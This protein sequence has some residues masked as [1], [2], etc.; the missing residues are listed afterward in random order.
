MTAPPSN[1][2]RPDLTVAYTTFNS[3]R[4]IERSVR[5]V[6]PVCRRVVVVDSGST[7]GT[8]EICRELGCEVV[9]KPWHGYVKSGS[10][11]LQMQAAIDLADDTEWVMLL[12]S[13]ECLTQELAES[14]RIAVLANDP[15]V[16]AYL[17]NRRHWYKGGW[18]SADF[19]DWKLRLFRRGRA[20]IRSRLVHEVP[21]TDG[22]T[23]RLEG[24]LR[25]ES[26]IDL[27]DALTRNIR[28]ARVAGWMPGRRTSLLKIVCNGP[29]AFTRTFLL[30][31][32]FREGW[33]GLEISCVFGV[34]TL[35]KHLFIREA[36]RARAGVPGEPPCETHE[37]AGSSS[38]AAKVDSSTR[39]DEPVDSAT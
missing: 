3:I 2:D 10:I 19:P 16:D 14:I 9:H 20:W 4:T 26:W 29:W 33:R 37:S 28:Y 25:H 39:V 24:L 7:D 35:M 17:L 30:Q 8:V 22:P 15:N 38:P 21:E 32:G 34:S 18:I 31:G 36:M 5:S 13:D 1:D 12:D 6:L 11:G 27:Q 23:R